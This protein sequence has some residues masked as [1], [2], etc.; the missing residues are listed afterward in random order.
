MAENGEEWGS[1]SG[2]L[3]PVPGIYCQGALCGVVDEI[4]SVW[5]GALSAD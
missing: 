2:G 5:G 1:G 4:P 3:L